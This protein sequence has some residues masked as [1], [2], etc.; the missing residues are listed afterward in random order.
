MLKAPYLFFG[1]MAF[2]YL[3][4]CLF[5]RKLSKE[6][7]KRISPPKEVPESDTQVELEA[8][9]PK[10]GNEEEEGLLTNNDVVEEQKENNK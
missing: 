1:F 8:P 7:L 2:G 5:T 4:C 6:D 10:E 3:I 9:K